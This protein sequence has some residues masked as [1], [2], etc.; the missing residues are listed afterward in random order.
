MQILHE[1]VELCLRRSISAQVALSRMLLGGLDAAAIV[2]AVSYARPTPPTSEWTTLDALV[3]SRMDTLDG[4]AAEVQ[5]AGSDHNAMGSVASV[6]AF[7]DRAVAYSPEAAVALYSL[8]EQSLLD[9]ATTEI[10]AWLHAEALI[11]CNARV[12]DLGCGTGRV[13]AALPSGYQDI[14]GVDVSAGMIAEARRRHVGRDLRFEVFDG[15]TVPSGPFDVA[16]LVDSMPYIYQAGLADP[17]M[18]GLAAV[19][20][21]QG[22]IVILNLSYRRDDLADHADAQRWAACLGLILSASRPFTLWDGAAFVFRKP[23]HRVSA[24]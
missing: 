6:A 24:G 9:A 21:T 15:R 14:L 17:V 5:K 11:P 3:S 2:S 12:L 8:G 19:L 23:V 16:L 10:I 18:S 22:A 13:A 7:F 1:A 20:D 4:L